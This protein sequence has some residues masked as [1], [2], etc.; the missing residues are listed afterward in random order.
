MS[1]PYEVMPAAQQ[2][3]PPPLP[4]LPQTYFQSAKGLAM[5]TVILMGIQAALNGLTA[6]SAFAAAGSLESG[7]LGGLGGLAAFSGI[8]VLSGVVGIAVIVVYLIWLY[9]AYSNLRALN[10]SFLGKFTPGWA[11]GWWFIPFANLVMPYQVVSEL[12]VNSAPAPTENGYPRMPSASIV[13]F[14]WAAFIL[15]GILSWGS[16]LG[17]RTSLSSIESTLYWAGITEIFAVIAGILCC[18]I[19]RRIDRNQEAT[20]SANSTPPAL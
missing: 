2:E 1:N 8:A 6:L 18:V 7:G 20:A 13:G 4:P 9:R 10:T 5:A 12:Y 3:S 14:W 19:V 11:V 17:G 16:G 15:R